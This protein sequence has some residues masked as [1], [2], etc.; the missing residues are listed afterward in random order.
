MVEYLKRSAKPPVVQRV[1]LMVWL[2]FVVFMSA[3]LTTRAC[4]LF[5]D[6]QGVLVGEPTCLF[7]PNFFGAAGQDILASASRTPALPNL[8]FTA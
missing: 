3:S 4:D 8:V 1:L 6:P 7:D 5:M 2:I